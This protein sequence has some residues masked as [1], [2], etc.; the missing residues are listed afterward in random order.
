[1]LCTSSVC[2][3]LRASCRGRDW[4]YAIRSLMSSTRSTGEI[5]S[6]IGGKL[7]VDEGYSV[8]VPRKF[9]DDKEDSIN[10]PPT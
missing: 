4:K 10:I 5:P 1:M 8:T 2:R 3:A 6:T 7:G 9:V